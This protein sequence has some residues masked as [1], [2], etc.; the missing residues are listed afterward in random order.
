MKADPVLADPW[1]LVDREIRH[2]PK[3]DRIKYRFMDWIHALLFG[4]GPGARLLGGLLRDIA[5]HSR[6]DA[7]LKRIEQ[8]IKAPLFGCESCGMCRLAETQYICPETCPKGLA[9]GACGGTDHNRCEFGDRECIHSRKYRISKDMGVLDQ[10]ECWL[11]PAVP[12]AVRNSSSWPPHFR[13]ESPKIILIE[14][15]HEDLSKSERS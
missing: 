14:F 3:R 12:K 6:L 9:N 15:V 10:L 8:A 13:G 2:A 5:R 11:I 1:Y 7:L 4:K